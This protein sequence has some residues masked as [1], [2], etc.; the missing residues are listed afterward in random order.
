MSYPSRYAVLL[1]GG[2]VIQKLSERSRPRALPSADE[3]ES[4]AVSLGAHGCV[5]DQTLLRIYFYHARPAS[6]CLRNPVS[7]A[8]T[9]LGKTDIYRKSEQLLEKLDLRP[10]FALRLGELEVRDWKLGERA[11]KSIRKT[12]RAI[13]ASD[14]APDIEQKGVDLRIGLDI[15]RFALD[16]SVQS[17]VVVTGDSDLIPA[18]KFARRE[19]LRVFLCHFNHGVKRELKAHADRVISVPLPLPALRSE[20]HHHVPDHGVVLERVG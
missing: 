15:A 14:F 19:G 18:F 3:I 2:F 11:L 9:D 12:R 13:Q 20:L 17:I 8:V 5:A 4:L 7:G 1:D 10:D 6:G 16:R